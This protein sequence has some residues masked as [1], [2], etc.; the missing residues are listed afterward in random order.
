RTY[1]G[2]GISTRGRK[3]A[4]SKRIAVPLVPPPVPP[5]D[6]K[7]TYDEKTITVT[8]DVVADGSTEGSESG[9]L[10][11]TPLGVTHTP[12]VYNVYDGSVKLTKA[13][14]AEPT[15]ADGRLA[16]GEKRCYI[17]RTVQ[18]LED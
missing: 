1:V 4:M 8:W 2:V 10:P 7:V 6:P 12:L 5:S 15:Y 14:V 9:L 11:S 18:R 13:P 3:G 17:V 16:W